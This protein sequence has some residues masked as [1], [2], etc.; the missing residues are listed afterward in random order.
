MVCL[1]K[2]IAAHTGSLL[3]NTTIVGSIANKD[4]LYSYRNLIII[5]TILR[6]GIT[7]LYES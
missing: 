5:K 1:I 3:S 4:L 7:P 6:V 2:L